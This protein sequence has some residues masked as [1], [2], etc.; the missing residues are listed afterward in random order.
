MKA[1]KFFAFLVP[2]HPFGRVSLRDRDVHS[3]TPARV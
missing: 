1:F 3:R 2:E